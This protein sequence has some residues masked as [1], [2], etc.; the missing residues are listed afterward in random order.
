MDAHPLIKNALI[1]LAGGYAGLLV[2]DKATT[3][4]M[5]V[6]SEADK[7]AEKRASPGAAYT[8]AARD[9]AGSIGLRLDEEKASSVGAVFH[10]GLGLGA[11]VAYM[12]LRRGAGMNPV[13]AALL[14]AGTLF[15][16]LDEGLN[17]AMGWSAPPSAYPAA[18]HLRG[19]AGHLVLGTVVATTAEVLSWATE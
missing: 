10:T 11:G 13:G 7:E 6:E 3:A 18:T 14:T 1:G 5:N 9:I 15:L 19:A 4:L 8:L 17:W 2:M 16:G 12:A